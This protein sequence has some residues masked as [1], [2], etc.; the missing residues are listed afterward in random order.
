MKKT[1][2]VI[3]ALALLMTFVAVAPVMAEPTEGQK[4]PAILKFTVPP[5]V[6]ILDPGETWTT[7]GNASHRRDTIVNYTF[8]LIIDGAPPIIGYA[9]SVRDG[10]GIPTKIGMIGYHEYY[11]FWFPTAGGGFEG[12]GLNHITD[13]VSLSSYNLD[14]HVVL[15]GTGA[16][17]GQTLNMW[18]EGP[19][20][21]GGWFGYLLK[22]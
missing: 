16:F 20:L 19:P 13:M 17:E 10:N 5:K 18:R 21:P 4:V 1:A 8:Q 7:P 15:H 9:I 11:E 22:P 14:L 6:T 12:R 2:V 3:L